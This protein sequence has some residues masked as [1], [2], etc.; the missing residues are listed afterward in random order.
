[1]KT[2]DVKGRAVA[3]GGEFVL[4]VRDTGTH[5]CYL[6]Y[7]KVEPGGGPAIINPGKGHEEIVMAVKGDVEVTG[8]V[9]GTLKEGQ[10]FHVEGDTECLLHTKGGQAAVYVCAGG[11]TPGEEHGSHE[12]PGPSPGL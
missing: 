12:S 10:A 8:A 9:N 1:M 5:A 3:E 6:I 11:H 2:F 4:G 7:G